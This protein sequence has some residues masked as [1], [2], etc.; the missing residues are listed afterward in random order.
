LEEL[1][2]GE[3]KTLRRKSGR[4]EASS[5]SLKRAF[6]EKKRCPPSSSE[7]KKKFSIQEKQGERFYSLRHIRLIFL[8][9]R[10]RGDSC[11]I[12]ERTIY[13][14]TGGCPTKGSH[15]QGEARSSTFKE[16]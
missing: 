8:K 11:R 14:W 16:V 7:K 9:K 15:H 6:R 3:R 5:S 4:G 13:Y 10:F 1:Y 12:R 2:L